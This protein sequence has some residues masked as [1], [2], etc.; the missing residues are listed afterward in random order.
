[1]TNENR[2]KMREAYSGKAVS[3][4]AERHSF[5]TC[6]EALISLVNCEEYLNMAR[7][8]PSDFTR[9]RKMGFASYIWYFFAA[10]CEEFEYGITS[11]STSIPREV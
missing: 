10:L 6:L 11:F 7:K 4:M 1:M 9:K 3:R 8:S 2:Q 5:E